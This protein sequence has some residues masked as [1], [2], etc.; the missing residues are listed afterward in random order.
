MAVTTIDNGTRFRAVV[1][2]GGIG[3]A[4][5]AEFTVDDCNAHLDYAALLA[6]GAVEMVQPLKAA[7]APDATKTSVV[8]DAPK[9]ADAVKPDAAKAPGVGA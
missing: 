8:S 2:L 3:V 4:E 6:S 1:E 9:P 7:K 5:G